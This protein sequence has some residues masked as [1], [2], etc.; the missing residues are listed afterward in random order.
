MRSLPLILIT[1]LLSAFL[2]IL[3][4]QDNISDSQPALPDSVK[5]SEIDS[6]LVEKQ[7]ENVSIEDLEKQLMKVIEARKSLRSQLNPPLLYS[8]E[9]FHYYAFSDPY[10]ILQKNGFSLLPHNL[11]NFH[12]LQNFQAL[13]LTRFNNGKLEFFQENYQLK[14][15]L[16]ES[17]LALGDNNMN[18]AGVW[19]AKG[20]VLGAR[21]INLEA[22]YLGQEG[23]WL[24]INETSRNFNLH[25]FK[26]FI[27]GEVHLNTTLLDQKISTAK[28]LVN[29]DL[30]DESVKEKF[31]DGSLRFLNKYL[32]LGLRYEDWKLDNDRRKTISALFNK[33]LSHLS[34]SLELTYEP[35]RQTKNT[36][37]DHCN[38]YSLDHLSDFS[39]FNWHNSAR[40]KNKTDFFLHSK[41]LIHLSDPLTLKI[42]F[43]QNKFNTPVG[44]GTLNKQGIGFKSTDNS[45]NS[46]LFFGNL[47]LESLILSETDNY[48]FVT[49]YDF[50]ELVNLINSEMGR[51]HFLVK[52]YIQ[53]NLQYP[54][55]QDYPVIP[56][57]QARSTFEFSID[58]KNDNA[59]ILGT[60][61]LFYSSLND[62]LGNTKINSGSYFNGYFS[63][64]ISKLFQI[65][66]DFIN[67][68]DE[69][70]F[71]YLNDLYQ[72]S[73][74]Y[75]YSR[76]INFSVNWI[77][78][79]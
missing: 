57:W 63:L 10:F 76:H 46:V 67:I 66:I 25:I 50:L 34:H 9:N 62:P 74:N 1:L 11:K 28:L 35:L 23:D 78:V 36:K 30:E 8:T 61:H 7:L 70:L 41:L 15:P 53:H 38:I 58:L 19:L 43:E 64:Q 4:S 65:K 73:K 77:F 56:E 32:N 51:Y 14:I 31:S 75:N 33:K 42:V 26:K 37:I 5:L 2:T 13:M 45:I 72:I 20:D 52:N 55:S 47:N 3:H 71:P 21:G 44:T 60:D 16:T 17:F 39:G 49:N 40:F 59:V 27:L 22:S 48:D 6:L 79:N 24:G 69:Q 18:H 54:N 68:T 12:L 29:Y